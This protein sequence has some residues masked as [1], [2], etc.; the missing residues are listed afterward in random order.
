MADSKKVIQALYCRAN[1]ITDKCDGCQYQKRFA[2][3]IGCDFMAVCRDA[4]EIV[5]DQ[6]P[7]IPIEDSDYIWICGNC[8]EEIYNDGELRD[9]YC[10]NCGRKVKWE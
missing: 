4:L 10:A 5:A 1:T 7:V 9:N 3:R 6:E 2:N 8:G